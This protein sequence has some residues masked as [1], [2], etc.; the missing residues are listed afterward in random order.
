MYVYGQN[1]YGQKKKAAKK[2]VDKPGMT[3][4]QMCTLNYR[5]GRR[6]EDTKWLDTRTS[7][8]KMLREEHLSRTDMGS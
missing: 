6:K 8:A 3:W 1:L 2:P 5:R 7:K 4:K